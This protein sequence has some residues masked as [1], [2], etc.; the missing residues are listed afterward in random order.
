MPAALESADLITALKE[1]LDKTTLETKLISNSNSILLAKEE[2]IA[3]YRVFQEFLN[4]SIKHSKATLVIIKLELTKNKLEIIMTD[5]GIGFNTNS[6]K[7]KGRGLLTMKNRIDSIDA[8]YKLES[9]K[10]KGTQLKIELE[11][12]KQ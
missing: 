2:K 9:S 4:N 11:C 1:L 12:K 10:G 6:K 8:I 3:I 5:N 7:F